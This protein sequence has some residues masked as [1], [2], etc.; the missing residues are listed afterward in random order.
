MD[1]MEKKLDDLKKDYR[2]IEAPEFMAS[3][4]SSVIRMKRRRIG[5]SLITFYLLLHSA[6]FFW[7]Y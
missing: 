6:W 5:P 3:R 7:F 1:E 2:R 4:I